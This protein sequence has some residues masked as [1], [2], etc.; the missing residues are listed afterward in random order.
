MG[1]L[2]LIN[3]KQVSPKTKHL[4]IKLHFIRDLVGKDIKPVHVSTSDQLAD[5]LTKPLA[6]KSYSHLRD[7]LLHQKEEQVNSTIEVINQGK[8]SSTNKMALLMLSLIIFANETQQFV[9]RKSIKTNQVVYY[10]TSP[11]WDIDKYLPPKA[12]EPASVTTFRRQAFSMCDDLYKQ[13]FIKSVKEFDECDHTR[14]KRDLLEKFVDGTVTVVTNLIDSF[15]VKD[16]KAGRDDAVKLFY[17]NFNPAKAFHED[18]P[19][20]LRL[21]SPA[22]TSHVS[23]WMDMANHF[24]GIIWILTKTH[25]E[26]LAN[27][28]NLK[29]LA[30]KC[31]VG[32]LAASE[33][34]E[35]LK[36]PELDKLEE[37]EARITTVSTSDYDE[38][39]VIRFETTTY[40]L[41]RELLLQIA[42]LPF[43]IILLIIVFRGKVVKLMNKIINKRMKNDSPAEPDKTIKIELN[44]VGFEEEC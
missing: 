39:I 18:A 40:E 21:A 29:A 27:S 9:H 16:N 2:R 36:I 24:S 19:S 43:G 10:L 28:A 13:I 6:E 31:R 38:K 22:S 14:S 37:N 30:A 7:Q 17:E 34:A 33:L 11:C 42:V 32:Q 1:C 3:N 15:I 26:I 4:D 44:Q 25:A 41:D 20:L 35:I 5:I 8:M 12:F 23:E